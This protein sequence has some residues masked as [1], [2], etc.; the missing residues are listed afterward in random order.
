MCCISFPISFRSENTPAGCISAGV[1]C[2]EAFFLEKQTQPEDRFARNYVL[3]LDKFL[4]LC[5]NKANPVMHQGA[6]DKVTNTKNRRVP[7]VGTPAVF[8]LQYNQSFCDGMIPLCA[9]TASRFSPLPFQYAF[10]DRQGVWGSG[11][12]SLCPSAAWQERRRC[13]AKCNFRRR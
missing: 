13:Q 5:H 12:G 2:K 9:V 11:C 8:I 3:L 6:D 7:Q 1:F 10:P 4:L